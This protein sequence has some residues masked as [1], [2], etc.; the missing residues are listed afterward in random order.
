[1]S[2]RFRCSVASHPAPKYPVSPPIIPSSPVIPFHPVSLHRRPRFRH[3]ITL[4][5]FVYPCPSL[6]N[7][8][9]CKV[10][11]ICS[12]L[13]LWSTCLFG[14]CSTLDCLLRL[15]CT[16][17]LLRFCSSCCFLSFCSTC[18][19]IPLCSTSRLLCL[20][21]CDSTC[22]LLCLFCFTF[23]FSGLFCSAAGSRWLSL[24]RLLCLLSRPTGKS[25][26]NFAWDDRH[27]EPQSCSSVAFTSRLQRRGRPSLQ[28]KVLDA[29]CALGEVTCS[30]SSAK[31]KNRIAGMLDVGKDIVSHFKHS[32]LSTNALLEQQREINPT[33]KPRKL[34][35]TSWKNK[36]Q[37]VY[38]VIVVFWSRTSPLLDQRSLRNL[39][40]L[41][42]TPSAPA[43]LDLTR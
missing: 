4:L 41:S 7:V 21:C 34:I 33:M 1:M 36:H 3:L 22:R 23:R 35:Q 13:S 10:R 11:N 16:C 15:C 24:L 14:L 26:R 32:E 27:R 9:S 37:L 30:A 18:C 29:E 40:A 42:T 19:S 6:G 8:R 38:W 17:F 39:E 20:V 2:S 43:W 25:R 28:E 5:S 12:W 31:F